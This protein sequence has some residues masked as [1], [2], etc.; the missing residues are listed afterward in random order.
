[1]H[2]FRVKIWGSIRVA[3]DV[4]QQRTAVM[5]GCTEGARE[6]ANRAKTEK[7]TTYNNSSSLGVHMY[8]TNNPDSRFRNEII[9]R[10]DGSMN[11]VAR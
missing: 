2:V 3:N 7:N 8:D 9:K 5:M 4:V 10:V 1:M 11:C 6:K